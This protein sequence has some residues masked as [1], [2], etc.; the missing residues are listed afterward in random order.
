MKNQYLKKTRFFLFLTALLLAPLCEGLKAQKMAEPC[1]SDIIHDKLMA[2][3][4]EYAHKIKTNETLLQKSI[5][6][7]NGGGDHTLTASPKCITCTT[8]GIV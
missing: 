1:L 6:A 2:S 4:P 8:T 5:A 3:N 7:G